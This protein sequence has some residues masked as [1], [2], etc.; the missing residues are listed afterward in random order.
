[1]DI[2]TGLAA[3][4]SRVEVVRTVA[5]LLKQSGEIDRLEIANRLYLVSDLLLDARTALIDAQEEQ[6]KLRKQMAELNHSLDF[7]KSLEPGHGIYYRDGFPYCPVCWEADVKPVRLSGGF[8]DD[9][10]CSYQCWTCPIHK[11][12]YRI[13]PVTIHLTR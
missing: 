5:T 1:M 13:P 4:K 7:G 2:A 3:A 10:D 8:R 12:N 6:Q 11:A 9:E